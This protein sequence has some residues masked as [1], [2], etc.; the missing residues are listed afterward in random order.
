MKINWLGLGAIIGGGLLIFNKISSAAS[1]QIT[2]IGAALTLTGIIPT[3]K[4]QLQITNPTSGNLT[5]TGI[6]GSA[7]YNNFQVGNLS[8]AS[9]TEITPGINNVWVPIILK[10]NANVTL[11]TGKVVL[12][13]KG[14]VYQNN[15]SYSF[16]QT[17]P[18]L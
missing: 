2:P 9:Q 5:I 12:D 4:V 3:I 11:W 18:V 17:V 13:L 7:S 16:A 14:K 6:T 1:L 15:A 10:P 8:Y